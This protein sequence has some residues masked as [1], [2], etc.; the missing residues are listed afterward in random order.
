MHRLVALVLLLA[1]VGCSGDGADDARDRCFEQVVVRGFEGEL[2]PAQIG[3]PE[4]VC[5]VELVVRV[6]DLATVLDRSGV[7]RRSGLR[8]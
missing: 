7:E 8:A 4:E 5:N 6:V 3:A 2:Q 1:L